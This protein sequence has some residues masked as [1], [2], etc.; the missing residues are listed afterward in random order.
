MRRNILD[1]VRRAVGEKYPL[2]NDQYRLEVGD[3][4]YDREDPPTLAEQKRA[5]LRRQSLN[6]KLQGTWRLVDRNTGQVVDEKRTVVA[7]VPVLTH[8]GTYIYNGNEYA[9]CLHGTTRVWTEEGMIPIRDIVKEKKNVRVWSWDWEQ[10]KF[11]LQ[12]LTGWYENKTSRGLG[13]LEFDKENR[14]PGVNSYFSTLWGTLDHEVYQPD[15]RK[16]ALAEATKLLAVEEKLSYAQQQ[17][18]YGSQLGDGHI[19]K[20][21]LFQVL[22]GHAQ[23]GYVE[24]KHAILRSV[25]RE[26]VKYLE[27]THRRGHHAGKTH[28][29][30][31]FRT[32]AHPEFKRARELMYVDGVKTVTQ[33]W[34]DAVDEMG[35]AFWFGD[36]GSSRYTRSTNHAVVQLHTQGFATAGVEL[37]RAWL[38][39]RWELETYVTRAKRYEG[40]EMGWVVCLSGGSAERLLSIVAPYLPPC[41]HYKLLPAPATNSCAACGVNIRRTRKL[42][43]ACLLQREHASQAVTKSARNRLGGTRGVRELQAGVTE[44]GAEPDGTEAW[45]ERMS[46]A[47]NR[48]AEMEA[49]NVVEY[50][51]VAIDCAYT[52]AAGRSYSKATTVYDLQVAGTHNYI[53]NGVLVSN[54]NQMRLRPGVYTRRKENGELEAHFNLLPGSGR[55]FRL[56]MEPQTG[57]FKMQIGQSHIPLYPIL[58][59]QGVTDKQLEKSWGVDL[60]NANRAKVDQQAM[61]KAY[62]RLVRD[63]VDGENHAEGLARALGRMEMDSEIVANNLGDWFDAE[64][65][66]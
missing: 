16:V 31:S 39:S 11:V 20:D 41:L 60:L 19:R 46:K 57:I 45:Q 25:T 12:P 10:E 35:L 9:V 52:G 42:C 34:L 58:R 63:P 49:D 7:H 30:W 13:C 27:Y 44:L 61:Q 6:H 59:A 54:C 28:A 64:G 23:R 62:Q 5:L 21:G 8:R 22:H 48:L 38:R 26:P 53:A 37:I 47:G 15:N 66:E 24:L 29:R 65:E 51:L 32:R 56:H 17:L 33:A 18:L 1:S 40:R 14:A 3:L 50:V 55:S 4:A 36:D 2:E 43:D